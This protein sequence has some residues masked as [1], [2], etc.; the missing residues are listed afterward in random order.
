MSGDGD[1][2][3]TDALFEEISCPKTCWPVEIQ[4]QC[5]NIIFFFFG[6]KAD[7]IVIEKYP[8]FFML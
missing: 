6:K 2:C 5:Q 8:E 7:S 1:C 4:S 3:K